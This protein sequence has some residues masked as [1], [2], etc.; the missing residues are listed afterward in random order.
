MKTLFVVLVLILGLGGCAGPQFS[1]VPLNPFVTSQDI[2]VVIVKDDQTR[3]GFL[4]AIERWLQ[5]ND[6]RYMI[7]ADGSEHDPSK[8]TLDYIGYWK[9][10]MAI[11]LS[12][13]SI[14]AFY[15]GNKIAKVDYKAPNTIN[16]GKFAVAS[17]RIHHMLDVLFGKISAEEATRIVNTYE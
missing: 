12:E 7:A 16:A 3:A 14:G 13:A 9:W 8:L 2:D 4:L 11:F 1:G 5:N 15:D 6:Y 10:D 17:E